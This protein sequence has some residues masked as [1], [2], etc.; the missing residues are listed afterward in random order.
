MSHSQ[1]SKKPRRSSRDENG[2]CPISPA[3]LAAFEALCAILEKGTY[4]HLALLEQWNKRDQSA[5]DAALTSELVRGVVKWQRLLDEMIRPFARVRI[6]KMDIPVL[7][8]L[9]MGVYQ[10][11]MMDRIPDYAAIS[12]AVELVRIHTFHA[13]RMANAVLR[14]IQKAKD[15]PLPLRLEDVANASRESLGLRLSYEEW[16]VQ[17]VLSTLGD[18]NGRAALAA[19][20]DRQHLALRVNHKKASRDQVLK[21]LRD[22]G[23][24]VSEVSGIPAAI[25]IEEGVRDAIQEVIARGEASYQGLS[26]MKIASLLRPRAGMTIIDACAAPGGKT[27]HLAELSD[28]QANIFA[29]EVHAH[30]AKM[31]QNQVERLGKN[32]ITVINADFLS[33][34]KDCDAILLDAPCSGLGTIAR[35]PDVKWTVHKE[36]LHSLAELQNSMLNHAADLLRAGG[37]LVYSVCTLTHAEGDAQIEKILAKRSDLELDWI[38]EGELA[39]SYRTPAGGVRMLPQRDRG[40]GFFVAR[41][42][43]R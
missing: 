42:R 30:R 22:A 8:A 28:D 1:G 17:E 40:D 7:C 43:K 36:D 33:V 14:A 5:Q 9:R 32:S 21:I 24:V 37:T 6:E 39:F 29:V 10:M 23:C 38:A 41:F 19:M 4:T 18:V 25:L 31:I 2:K 27:L 13:H 26:S 34:D 15:L 20:N 16:M 3:R 12:E 11:R 35:K